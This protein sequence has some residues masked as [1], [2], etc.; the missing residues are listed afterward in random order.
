MAENKVPRISIQMPDEY[1]AHF[2]E[3][4]NEAGMSVTGLMASMLLDIADDDRKAH[5][6][7]SLDRH[8]ATFR[9]GRR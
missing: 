2:Q 5:G 6:K 9:E 7:P 3:M 4:A 1:R 8:G